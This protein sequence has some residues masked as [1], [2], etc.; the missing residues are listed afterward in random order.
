MEKHNAKLNT[1]T[2]EITTE[3]NE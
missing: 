2:I 1:M 3:C